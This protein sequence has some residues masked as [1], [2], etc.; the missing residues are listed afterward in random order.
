VRENQK[1]MTIWVSDNYKYKIMDDGEGRSE[2]LGLRKMIERKF[3]EAKKWHGM[4]RAR[5]RSKERVKIQVL[6]TFMVI[7]IKRI[8]RLMEENGQILRIESASLTPT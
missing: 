7:N 6:M 5:F 1:R 3:G 8:T 4:E 2:A